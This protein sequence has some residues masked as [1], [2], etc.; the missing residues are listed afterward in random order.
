MLYKIVRYVFTIYSIYKT[1]N[2]KNQACLDLPGDAP[3][4]IFSVSHE[5]C[6][7]YLLLLPSVVNAGSLFVFSMCRKNS[8][9]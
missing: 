4:G 9:V 6:H 5:N 7:Q 1:N 8:L 3:E 2:D